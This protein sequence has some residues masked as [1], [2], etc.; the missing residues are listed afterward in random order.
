MSRVQGTLNVD[1]F[2]YADT[3]NPTTKQCQHTPL[4]T[5]CEYKKTKVVQ[6]LLGLQ[7]EGVNVVDISAGERRRTPL[8]IAAA[9]N[10]KDIVNLLI[11]K[12]CQLS[13]DKK[14]SK[15]LPD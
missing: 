14:V 6:Y 4:M 9:H 2:F 11:D 15:P 7:L 1:A 10:S 8:H 12:D 3:Y 5:A 13:M